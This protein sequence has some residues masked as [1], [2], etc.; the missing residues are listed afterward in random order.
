MYDPDTVGEPVTPIPPLPDG[1]DAY[2]P[3]VR[4]LLL[5]VVVPRLAP[6]DRIG[7]ARRIAL[8]LLGAPSAAIDA[9]RHHDPDRRD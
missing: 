1:W 8:R 2:W 3:V 9:R 6:V 7:E 5:P 4:H